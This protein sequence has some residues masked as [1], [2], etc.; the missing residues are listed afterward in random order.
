M[1][2]HTIRNFFHGI[3]RFWFVIL[4]GVWILYAVFTDSGTSSSLPPP[5]AAQNIETPAFT[6]D[7]TPGVSL[8]NGTVLKR[9]STYMQGYGELQISNGTSYDA[10][11]KLIR[12][13]TSVFSVY[14]KANSNYTIDSIADGTYWLAFAQGTDW[15]STTKSF[16]RNQQFSSFEDTFDFETSD[17]QYTTYEI[18]LN[19]VAGGTA[20]TRDVNA[21][22]FAAY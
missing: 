15:N 18:T 11:A 8:Q 13:G 16:N 4:I 12:N 9:I 3:G 10:V 17:E 22:Q 19:P 5:V 14:I 21:D 6:P 2:S 20:E 7:L 1:N